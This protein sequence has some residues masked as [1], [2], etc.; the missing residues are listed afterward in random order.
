M[1]RM[2]IGDRESLGMGLTLTGLCLSL[3]SLMILPS[4]MH[5]LQ[6]FY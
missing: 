1:E 6:F 3:Q 4:S 5:Q 2:D